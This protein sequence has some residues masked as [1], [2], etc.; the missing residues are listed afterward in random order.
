MAVVDLFI[1]SEAWEDARRERNQHANQ[2]ALDVDYLLK[3]P[4]LKIT[5]TSQT[6]AD[7]TLA[8]FRRGLADMH[9]R[10]A[11]MQHEVARQEAI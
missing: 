6:T 2:V 5:S 1:R 11:E 9:H 8:M 3:L 10:H 7:H 4:G